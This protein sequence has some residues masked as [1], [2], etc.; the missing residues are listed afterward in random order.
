MNEAARKQD[1]A[2]AADRLTVVAQRRNH[3]PFQAPQVPRASQTAHRAP[4][5]LDEQ[6]AG[7]GHSAT[8][9]DQGRAEDVQ[10]GCE[11]DAEEEARLIE[12]VFGRGAPCGGRLGDISG[13]EVAACLSGLRQ[14]GLPAAADLGQGTAPEGGPGGDGFQAAGAGAGGG[15]GGRGPRPPGPRRPPQ[16]HSAWP[17]GSTMIWPVSPLV[18]QEKWT[19]PSSRVTTLMAIPVPMAISNIRA[20]WRPRA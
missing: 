16:V 10:I 13:L 4:D 14:E 5:G 18:S 6:V 3:D 11:S 7:L 19:R 9:H 15:G 8:Q 1:Q 2:R 20:V 17:K 12:D